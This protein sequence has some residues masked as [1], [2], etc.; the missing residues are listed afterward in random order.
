MRGWHDEYGD[1]GLVV[2]GVHCPEFERER[3]ID[4][5]RRYVAE[6]DLRLSRVFFDSPA[7]RAG[8]A[9]GQQIVA[10]VGQ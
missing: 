9:R 4:D 6:N 10:L 5:V 1:Q 8:L 3:D 7:N 2:I